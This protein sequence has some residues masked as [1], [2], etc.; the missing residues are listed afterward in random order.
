MKKSERNGSW[1]RCDFCEE[2]VYRIEVEKKLNVC[3]KCNY[4]FKI[5]AHKK[6]NL[7]MDDGRLDEYDSHLEAADP[8]K[9]RD[10][11]RYPDRIREDQK[12]TGLKEAIVCGRGTIY[13]FSA[14]VAIMDFDFMGG[15]MGCVV[16]E[17]MARLVEKAHE[18]RS[19]LI[20]FSAS[21]G[22]R[23]QEGLFSLMQM[24]KTSAALSRLKASSVPYISIVTH[25]TTGGVAASFAMLGDIIIAEPRAL[26]GFA[27]PRVIEK[28]IRE[29]LPEGFQ[30]A[31]YLLEHGMIDMIVERKDLKDSLGTLL[32]MLSS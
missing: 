7:I 20:V 27:G 24:A 5:P 32:D 29:S 2:I 10:S 11:K 18:E 6:I 9:F 21:G 31:E 19:P 13:G 17:K 15:S 26:I 3:P 22:A 4:H 14:M 28:T 30:R 16:G 12:K 25:P 23:M 1:I 8:L